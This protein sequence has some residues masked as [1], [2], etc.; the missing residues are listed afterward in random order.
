MS[1][2]VFEFL[3]KQNN[4]CEINFV[5]LK[6]EPLLQLLTVEKV[7]FY[8][9]NRVFIKGFPDDSTVLLRNIVHMN[10]IIDLKKVE[11]SVTA[12]T[13]EV[14]EEALEILKDVVR[15][16]PLPVRNGHR[17]H[18]GEFKFDVKRMHP[19]GQGVITKNTEISVVTINEENLNS[20]KNCNETLKLLPYLWPYFT[21]NQEFHEILF[22]HLQR[23]MKQSFNLVISE[24]PFKLANELLEKI[25]GAKNYST[26][27]VAFMNHIKNKSDMIGKFYTW[28]GKLIE[29]PMIFSKSLPCCKIFLTPICAQ[30]YGIEFNEKASFPILKKFNVSTIPDAIEVE[31]KSMIFNEISE[32][33][34]DNILG[35]YF[36]RSKIVS[37]EQVTTIEIPVENILDELT[38]KLPIC[39]DSIIFQ[40]KLIQPHTTEKKFSKISPKTKL[41]RSNSINMDLPKISKKYATRSTKY[42]I[43]NDIP[44]FLKKISYDVYNWLFE[45]NESKNVMIYGHNGSGKKEILL[46]NI[47]LHFRS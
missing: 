4:Q 34:V 10:D 25:N 42:D 5:L 6:N 19:V 27:N 46:G 29:I 7:N 2:E 35:E 38:W 39:P 28:S 41:I 47:Y 9:K 18:I 16:D 44:I 31:A 17:L 40:L 45:A 24:I 14:N 20:N 3:K 22:A 11:F 30:N 1:P 37:F 15:T 36:E 43:L 26:S 33:Q 12:N 21:K 13:C 23:E 8:E 32:S